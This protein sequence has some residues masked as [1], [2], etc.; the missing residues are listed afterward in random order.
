MKAKREKTSMK[1]LL[2][3]MLELPKEVV[4]NLP[5]VTMIGNGE[6]CVENYKSVIEYTETRVRVN[7]TCGIFAIEGKKL[8]LNQIT[9]D[10]VV[11]KGV[12]D[13]MAFL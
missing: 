9:S 3:G 1:D 13:N 5:L 11:I 2:S 12:V 7:T 8:V 10:E 6:V 4:L